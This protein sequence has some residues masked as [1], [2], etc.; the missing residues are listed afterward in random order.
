MRKSI[1]FSMMIVLGIP[2]WAF[3]FKGEKGMLSSA[4]TR[5]AITVSP[6]NLVVQQTVSGRVIGTDGLPLPGVS[7]SVVGSEAAT[8]TNEAGN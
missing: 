3:G 7:I 1:Q 5:G 2:L 6:L 8:S 4:L